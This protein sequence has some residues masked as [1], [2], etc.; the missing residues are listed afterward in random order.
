[1]LIVISP[2]KT[3]DFDTPS[4]L[5]KFTQPIFLDHAQELIDTLRAYDPTQISQLM[6]ISDKLGEL[7]WQR[8]QEWIP[9][10]TPDNAKPALLAFRG[11]VYTGLDADSFT[12]ADFDY[13]QKHLRILSGLYGLL[14]PLDL[15]QAYR[16]EM[17]TTL[18]NARGRNLY[19]FWGDQITEALNL[20]LAKLKKPVLINLA[21][22][23]YFKA[24]R[25]KRLAGEVLTPHFKERK[26]SDYKI[27][28]FYAK[29]ARGLMSAYILKHRIETLDGLKEFAVDGYCFNAGLSSERDWVFTRD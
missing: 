1:M 4:P 12:R 13:A 18:R 6:G 25:P 29:K 20:E 14:K 11:D 5:K 8:F 15:M 27:V 3:L 16:L 19:E 17:S 10:F 9:T 26:G 23:E 22:E 7:N 28:S 24:V 21:S 2:A